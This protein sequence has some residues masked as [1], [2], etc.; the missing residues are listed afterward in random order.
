M[1]SPATSSS[2]F[3]PLLLL[4]ALFLAYGGGGAQ[5]KRVIRM[6]TEREEPDDNAV[7]REG[8]TRWAVLVAGSNGFGNYRHQV[9]A[10]F[11]AP[12][13]KKLKLG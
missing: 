12:L 4:V 10:L 6:P 13:F 2:L 11:F 1:A 8:G 7:D 5:A 3:L 9:A